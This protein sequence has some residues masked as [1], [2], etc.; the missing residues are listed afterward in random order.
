MSLVH[1]RSP[2]V[3]KVIHG[4]C[5]RHAPS[6]TWISYTSAKARCENKNR[7]N[8]WRYGGRGIEFRFRD[9][10]HF[11]DV[12]GPRPDGTS[13]DR[14]PNSS[15]HYEPGNV[16]WATLSQQNRNKKDWRNFML[17]LA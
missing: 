6:P 3:V 4:H 14:Y 12:L 2:H 16:R 9:F 7:P 5:K 13:L 1:R 15:G 8:Y 10:A 17:G 11:L